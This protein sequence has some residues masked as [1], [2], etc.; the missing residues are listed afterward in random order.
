MAPTSYPRIALVP[1]PPALAGLDYHAARQALRH[2]PGLRDACLSGLPGAE[3]QAWAC[4]RATSVAHSERLLDT[5]I[6]VAAAVQSGS[7]TPVDAHRRLD[8]AID[9]G[10]STR[11]VSF[12]DAF[13]QPDDLVLDDTP[14]LASMPPIQLDRLAI[15]VADYSRC[16]PG[17]PSPE[18]VAALVDA[19]IIAGAILT[20]LGTTIPGLAALDPAARVSALRR[21]QE[22]WPSH[23]P[24]PARRLVAGSASRTARGS[25]TAWASRLGPLPLM[26]AGGAALHTQPR[27]TVLRWASW[28]RELETGLRCGLAIAA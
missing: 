9:A 7:I 11:L 1:I 4:D 18:V 26:L 17:S 8:D 28:R 3:R 16:R 10:T 12:Q 14:P 20:Q 24:Q 2:T 21:L 25:E 13:D 15:A 23:V 22:R 19:A 6:A 27:R 5:A